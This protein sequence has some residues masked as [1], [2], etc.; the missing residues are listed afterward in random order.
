MGKYPIETVRHS[1]AHVMAA[2]VQNLYPNV[3][4]GMGPAIVNGFYYDFDFSGAGNSLAPEDLPKIEAKMQEILASGVKF[5]KKEINISEAK[6]KFAGQCYKLEIIK[7]L[8]M[9][10]VGKVAI[11]RT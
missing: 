3:K 6:E 9:E 1:L 8:E 10:D 7:D 5:E 11:G 2:A 4:F